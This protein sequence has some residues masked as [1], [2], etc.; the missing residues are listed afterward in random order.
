VKPI[1][2]Q[3]LITPGNYRRI[4]ARIVPSDQRDAIRPGIRISHYAFTDSQ[5]QPGYIIISH[6]T[7]RAGICFAEG[8]TEWG[9]WDGEVSTITTDGGRRYTLTGRNVS[10]ERN[11]PR[12]H[13][14]A[15][16]AGHEP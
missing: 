7:G 4:C 9:K 13:G 12:E 3:A 11:Q 2:R 16:Q 1:L 8:R 14:E 6:T 5:G 10:D 15:L